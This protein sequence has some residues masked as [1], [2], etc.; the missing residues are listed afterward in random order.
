MARTPLLR[1]L[2]RLAREH[3]AAERLGITPVALRSRRTLQLSRRDFLKGAAAAAAI[4][5]LAPNL[6]LAPAL[7]GPMPRIAI[8]G[9]GIAGLTAALTLKDKGI[10]ATVYEASTGVGGRMHS[11]RSGY[12]A[13]GQI[14][15]FCGELIELGPH[16]DS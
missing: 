1:A 9:A 12:W 7:A 11:D 13:D 16:N 2:Q 6:R 10:S 8:V 3:E 5:S 14:S 4:G 15:E